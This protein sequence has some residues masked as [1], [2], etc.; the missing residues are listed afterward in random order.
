MPFLNDP[1]CCCFVCREFDRRWCGIADASEATA[2]GVTKTGI[3]YSVDFD[4]PDWDWAVAVTFPKLTERD[5]YYAGGYCG[6]GTDWSTGTFR[7]D[8]TVTRQSDS[9]LLLK[10]R[11][12][13]YNNVAGSDDYVKIEVLE[14]SNNFNAVLQREYTLDSHKNG[15]TYIPTMTITRREGIMSIEFGG[16]TI[17]VD[18]FADGEGWDSYTQSTALYADSDGIDN[19]TMRISFE[20]QWLT[21]DTADATGDWIV[22]GYDIANPGAGTGLDCPDPRI[23]SVNDSSYSTPQW[24][25]DKATFSIGTITI[26]S[27]DWRKIWSGCVG[28]Y[29]P[30]P[31]VTLEQSATGQIPQYMFLYWG[32]EFDGRY[33][34][35]PP[36]GTGA[37]PTDVEPFTGAMTPFDATHQSYTI[38]FVPRVRSTLLTS[39]TAGKR[40][41]RLE[42]WL[43]TVF[44]GTF[45]ADTSWVYIYDGPTGDW[46]NPPTSTFQVGYD[47]PLATQ[48][49]AYDNIRLRNLA[50]DYCVYESDG[51]GGYRFR[52]LSTGVIIAAPAGFDESSTTAFYPFYDPVYLIPPLPTEEIV[53][54][55]VKWEK[56]VDEWDGTPPTITFGSADIVTSAGTADVVTALSVS[57]DGVYDITVKGYDLPTVVTWEIPTYPFTYDYTHVN[58]N[59]DNVAVT[60]KPTTGPM[61]QPAT[62]P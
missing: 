13:I 47:P 61:P 57:F 18:E 22:F 52:N 5:N 46:V 55:Y 26:D 48:L 30:Y 21:G 43:P 54:V 8:V 40:L 2:A 35:T 41:V 58:V 25:V 49:A 50:N 27:S 24:E 45:G 37:W 16:E 19:D 39:A 23:C 42:M 12:T 31:N 29:T 7:H 14:T 53:E 44:N 62:L 59:F 9:E 32:K 4:L 51:A 28:N 1:G 56:E 36:N 34:Y 33:V 60:I 3:N 17:L 10:I 11:L 38:D 6:E 20:S 15:G